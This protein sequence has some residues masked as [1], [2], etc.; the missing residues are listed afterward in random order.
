MS[1][2]KRILGAAVAAACTLALAACG[3]TAAPSASD[4]ASRTPTATAPT[5][6]ATTK[7]TVVTHD[8]FA[9]TPALVERFEAESGYDVTLVARGDA[10]AVVNQLV[11]TKSAPLG[12]VVFGI[13][14]TFA[15]R[16]IA[17]RIVT[18]YA[19]TGISA[20]DA[21]PLQA[22]AA[23]SLTPIDFGDV[24]VNADLTWFA[25]KNLPLPATLDDLTKPQYAN[26]LVVQNPASSSPGLAFLAATVGAKGEGYLDYWAALKANGV[27]VAKGWT[28][29]YS[30]EFSGGEGKG[31]YPLVVSYATSPAFTTDAA[32]T[33]TTTG[34]LLGTCFRQVEYAGV[35]AGTKNEA[36]A[37]AFI[38]FL[39]S[40]A[41]QADIPGQMYMYP[42]V[43]A[44]PLPEAW[45]TFAPLSDK[46]FDVPAAEI[47]AQR[48]TWI[49][50]WTATVIG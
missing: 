33:S 23:G 32:G 45:V 39:L 5:S 47:A 50:A 11:L 28:E 42:A 12:D 27:K 38:E 40:P 16:A 36:G 22:D 46:P 35:I 37:R 48:E 3:T 13:D 21:V 30:V 44:T 34:A 19:A 20:A 15:G 17:E 7:L 26:L 18:P 4:T 29:A 14:N 25:A 6:T 24:C 31:A 41:V 43:K 8:S 9:L 2:P 1:T 49:R 10:G